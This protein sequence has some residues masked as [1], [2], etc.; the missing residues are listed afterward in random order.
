MDPTSPLYQVLI[1][2]RNMR[3][4]STYQLNILKEQDLE[5]LMYVIEIYNRIMDN[6]ACMF[7]DSD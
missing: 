2:I 1:D 4:L 7:A 6:V 3:V 5:T